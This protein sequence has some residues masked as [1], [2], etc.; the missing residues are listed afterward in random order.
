MAALVPLRHRARCVVLV[1]DPQQLP[2]T[3]LSAAA[4]EGLFQR[5]L[6]ERLEQCGAQS[7]MLTVQYR[8][9]PSIRQWPSDFFYEARSLIFGW[10]E[11]CVA[12]RLLW[13]CDTRLP[14][15]ARGFQCCRSPGRFSAAEGVVCGFLVLLRPPTSAQQ[16]K[17]MDSKSVLERPAEAYHS[18]W[19]LLP[20]LVFDV[21]GAQSSAASALRAM[22]MLEASL[23]SPC[24]AAGLTVGKILLLLSCPAPA[25]GREERSGV[26]S[27]GNVAEVEMALGLYRKLRGQCAPGA[28][29]GRVAVISPYREQ[30]D[31]IRAAFAR[32]FGEANAN[33]EAAVDTIDGFQARKNRGVSDGV[34][35]LA[36]RSVT[37]GH[38][39]SARD[40]SGIVPRVKF[41]FRRAKRGM[42]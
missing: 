33:A 40:L 19:P 15:A 34:A 28:L 16:S 8:M 21:S 38:H 17:L 4:R 11:H 32:E 2:A 37:Q 29:R 6:F 1:G 41:R 5:S 9:E 36:Y 24:A 10:T 20:Y 7:L 3:V 26:G 22:V 23:L 27:V 14:R 18:E 30:R 42:S 39:H 13:K 12:P 31:A 35:L 25:A